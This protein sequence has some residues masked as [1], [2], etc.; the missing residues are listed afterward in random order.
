M[1]QFNNRVP[2]KMSSV[3]LSKMVDQDDCSSVPFVRVDQFDREVI[4]FAK[5][6]NLYKT[7][8]YLSQSPK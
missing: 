4:S 6:N 5:K 1:N 2:P 7:V 3:L 8:D